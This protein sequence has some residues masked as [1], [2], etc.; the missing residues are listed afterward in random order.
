MN[1]RTLSWLTMM[2]L[3]G[4]ASMLSICC[5]D[6]SAPGLD[7]GLRDGS[8]IDGGMVDGAV[9]GFIPDTAFDTEILGDA[10]TIVDTGPVDTIPPPMDSRPPV[11]PCEGITPTACPDPC[12][13]GSTCTADTCGRMACVPG[14]PCASDD[15]CGG[16]TCVIPDGL[17]SGTCAASS[18]DCTSSDS[19][20]VG[21][22]CEGGSC[23]NRRIPCGSVLDNCPRG[24]VCGFNPGMASLACIVAQ[25]R[26]T[27]AAQCEAGFTCGDIDGDGMN[28]CRPP[29]A[30]DENADCTSP[31]LCTVLSGS[32]ISQCLPDGPCG[33]DPS[34]CTGERECLDITSGEGPPRCELPGSC[35]SNSDCPEGQICAAGGYGDTL[36]CIGGPD[37]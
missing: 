21:S 31:L 26:C 32:S 17:E 29:G 37:A 27:S 35:S 19:C 11:D 14:R 28:E 34:V 30:C 15:D 22:A 6:D 33:G 10:T 25:N 8:M 7:V 5:S 4:G 9:D 2:V 16:S 1:R 20:P 13:A 23:V 18:G 36:R 3:L 12:P 24:Y